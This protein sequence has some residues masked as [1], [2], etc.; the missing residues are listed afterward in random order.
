M[1]I[2]ERRGKLKVD[3][4]DVEEA[5]RLFSDIRKSVEALEEYK[6]LMLV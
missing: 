2:A 4:Q 3:V 6:D 1:T 5:S